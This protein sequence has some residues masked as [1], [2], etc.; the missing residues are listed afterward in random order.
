MKTMKTH[1]NRY[2]V[3]ACKSLLGLLEQKRSGG[4]DLWIGNLGSGLWGWEKTKASTRSKG[5]T[6]NLWGANGVKLG[7]W[8]GEW[9]VSLCLHIIH[10]HILYN[11][12]YVQY[13]TYRTYIYIN[14]YTYHIY[15]I[16]LYYLYMMFFLNSPLTVNIVS[17]ELSGWGVQST[18]TSKTW[19]N[20]KLAYHIII[21]YNPLFWYIYI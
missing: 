6:M 9:V 14:I 19:W 7:E 10:I 17:W 1:E 15:M 12:L 2:V 13:Y 5:K 8:I 3:S 4:Q 20:T 21:Y 16:M 11:I 18:K